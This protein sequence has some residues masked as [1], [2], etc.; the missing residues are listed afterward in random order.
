MGI[1]YY[2]DEQK[3]WTQ[4]FWTFYIEL[5]EIIGVKDYYHWQENPREQK[6]KDLEKRERMI[7][8]TRE[9]RKYCSSVCKK[10]FL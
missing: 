5:N 2:T 9:M 1:K 10:R 3:N 8:K 6:K 4:L 7:K